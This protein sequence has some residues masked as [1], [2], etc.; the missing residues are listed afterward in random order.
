MKNIQQLRQELKAL[1][2][3]NKQVSVVNSHGSIDVRIKDINISEEKIQEI[4]KK[5]ERVFYCEHSQEILSGGNTFVSVSYSWELERAI[6]KSEEFLNMKSDVEE[7]LKLLKDN[8][9]IELAKGFVV[10]NRFTGIGYQ[11]TSEYSS[12]RWLLFTNNESLTYELF[13][14]V[15]QNKLA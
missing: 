10:F 14:A 1:N 5:Y 12:E 11:V 9:G 15:K 3:T 13:K 8:E 4:A 6:R 2:I 7:K